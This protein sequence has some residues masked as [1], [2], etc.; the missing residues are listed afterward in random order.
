LY[1]RNARVNQ[2]NTNATT[3]K[4]RG[5]AKAITET[6]N[7]VNHEIEEKKTGKSKP[8]QKSKQNVKEPLLPS[9]GAG[10]GRAGNPKKENVAGTDKASSTPTTSVESENPRRKTRSS[11]M[12]GEF[13]SPT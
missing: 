5:K 7:Q 3:A 4:K 1:R 6:Y 2:R 10:K 9:T 8:V 11:A 13:L 12:T